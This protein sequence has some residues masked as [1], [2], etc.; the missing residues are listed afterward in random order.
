MN[1]SDGPRV[2]KGRSTQRA[3]APSSRPAG[4]ASA[5]AA[6]K[7][8]QPD[9]VVIHGPTD[10]QKGLRVLR[11]RE[12]GLEVGEV[13][14]L[15]EGKPLAGEIVKLKPRPG[16]PRVCDVET[17]LSREEIDR[18]SGGAGPG[19]AGPRLGHAGPPRVS[20][21]AYRANWE[22]IYRSP[23]AADTRDLN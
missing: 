14:P 23:G 5:E 9:V 15:V 20:S 18:M 6:A 2:P 11:A 12:Q 21:D 16:M 13:R 10:D 7:E 19:G 8:A 22:A 3:Q 1:H 17:Q 4:D